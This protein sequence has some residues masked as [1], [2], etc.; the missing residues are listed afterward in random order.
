MWSLKISINAKNRAF[1]QTL[2]T[3]QYILVIPKITHTTFGS[4]TID[5][6]TYAHDILIRLDGSIEKRKKKL[7]K[8]VYGTS[9]TVSLAEA[10]HIFESGVDKLIIGAGKFG[11]VKLS[12]NAA[13][14]FDSHQCEVVLFPTS[15]A[16]KAWNAAQGNLIGLFH[17]TC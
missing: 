3:T 6:Q 4:I 13:K 10:E 8:E 11:R 12:E 16:I 9:H 2:R 7:S 1:I 15:R 14:F 5:N 17:I